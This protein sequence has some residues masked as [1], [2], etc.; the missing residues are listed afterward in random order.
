MR[1][2]R[3]IGIWATGLAA[4]FL[5]GAMIGHVLIGKGDEAGGGVALMLAF[6]CLRLWNA[7]PSSP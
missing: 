1:L 2:A 3:E 4:A 5:I 7:P 6:T